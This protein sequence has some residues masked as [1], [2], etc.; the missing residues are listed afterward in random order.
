METARAFP[1]NSSAPTSSRSRE[2][3]DVVN[4]SSSVALFADQSYSPYQSAFNSTSDSLSVSDFPQNPGMHSVIH[5]YDC[6]IVP[7]PAP[8]NA[9]TPVIDAYDPIITFPTSITNSPFLQRNSSTGRGSINSAGMS[10]SALLRLSTSYARASPLS[11]RDLAAGSPLSPVMNAADALRSSVNHFAESTTNAY[12]A[13]GEIIFPRVEI[14]QDCR[15]EEHLTE[16]EGV[17]S[18]ITEYLPENNPSASIALSTFEVIAEEQLGVR[19]ISSHERSE[20]KVNREQPLSDQ[21]YQG[22]D[23][24]SFMPFPQRVGEHGDKGGRTRGKGALVGVPFGVQSYQSAQSP[25]SRRLLSSAVKHQSRAVPKEVFA[26]SIDDA[27]L[28]LKG[29][30]EQ[31]LSFTTTPVTTHRTE[32]DDQYWYSLKTKFSKHS[33]GDDSALS[34][35]DKGMSPITHKYTNQISRDT[36][37]SIRL[38]ETLLAEANPDQRISIIKRLL[39]AAMT[40]RDIDVVIYFTGKLVDM[41]SI[42]SHVSR[43]IT[44]YIRFLEEHGYVAKAAALL[45][46]CVENH[47]R[48]A[49]GATF[50]EQLILK[51]LKLYES[52]GEYDSCYHLIERTV[53]QYTQAPFYSCCSNFSTG[54]NMNRHPVSLDKYWRVIFFGAYL[55]MLQ[56]NHSRSRDI[57]SYLILHT[58]EAG[59]VI[60]DYLELEL[61][62]GSFKCA[63]S[64][65]F[66][67]FLREEILYSPLSLLSFELMMRGFPNNIK[68]IMGILKKMTS[69]CAINDIRWK[70]K[71][72]C[73]LYCIRNNNAE[74]A[75]NLCFKALSCAKDGVQW[76]IFVLIAKIYFIRSC[77]S[78]VSDY[79]VRE[80]KE[81]LF[82][83]LT[84]A[85]Q[86]APLKSR[87]FVIIERAHYY[88]YYGDINTALSLLLEAISTN[89]KEWKY[90]LEYANILRRHNRLVEALESIAFSLTLGD[91]VSTGRLWAL[92]ASTA[93]SK[94]A[95]S[96]YMVIKAAVYHCPKSA[97]V[98][99]ELARLF[100]NPAYNCF[101]IATAEDA[102]AKAV[103]Y[104]PQYGDTYIEWLRLLVIK[105][106]VYGT[107]ISPVVRQCLGLCI[108]MKPTYGNLWSYCKAK[109]VHLGY[110]PVKDYNGPASVSKSIVD[111]AFFHV[112]QDVY[113]NLDLY[114]VACRFQKEYTDQ[115]TGGVIGALSL[116]PEDVQKKTPTQR[117]YNFNTAIGLFDKLHA[118]ALNNPLSDKKE[119]TDLIFGSDL[120]L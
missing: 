86:T 5:I 87:L 45:I 109:T 97:D 71:C 13:N 1:R 106:L 95:S 89:Q 21:Y 113:Q 40:H 104:T 56:G 58:K 3:T 38:G 54:G 32:D 83:N 7:S 98:W 112:I 94:G 93:Q 72:L 90:T 92:Y 39:K 26:S 67:Y 52:I 85:Y 117:W 28:P 63:F 74:Q 43:E 31:R 4:K 27:F 36:S 100:L 51:A 114:K 107:N 108:D 16:K 102:L 15:D 37:G 77:K 49:D 110:C 76:R 105:Y 80:M 12:E 35:K 9:P 25:N 44:D 41:A 103:Y 14:L 24:A 116:R 118:E 10:G 119:R 70:L 34:G 53:Q 79:W 75:L 61:K 82:N 68:L 96:H 62:Y 42:D 17:Q 11:E 46:K 20:S 101:N 78:N 91:N 64:Y 84:Q 88:E 81:K 8:W 2:V 18:L 73:A 55:E 99:V 22:V 50:P 19:S 59:P 111:C 47:L 69:S 115:A 23:V 6:H 66:Q 33:I 30:T 57:I 29:L 60:V 48:S 120:V 65:I